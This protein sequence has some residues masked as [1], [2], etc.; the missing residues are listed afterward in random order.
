MEQDE[1]DFEQVVLQI[2]YGG[3]EWTTI[4]RQPLLSRSFQTNDLK[5]PTCNA[6][7]YISNRDVYA[8]TKNFA[9]LGC[10][11]SDTGTRVN[12]KHF[13]SDHNHEKR[14]YCQDC[15][16]LVCAYCQLYGVHKDH[17][18]AIASDAA[19]PSIEA[20]KVAV[21]GIKCDLGDLNTGEKVVKKVVKRL[22]KN[23]RQ[24]ERR[25]KGYF[26]ELIHSL[27]NQRD[28]LLMGVGT[29]TDEQM[30]ILNAQLE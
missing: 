28:S 7:N 4:R 10:R 17:N 19:Q 12:K 5:C 2:R 27:E 22:K 18:C 20:L 21:D 3:R 25:V 9:L 23:R 14:V 1:E 29:W 6:M 16:K 11:P 8:L 24:C 15:R 30:Y 13:C 26:N